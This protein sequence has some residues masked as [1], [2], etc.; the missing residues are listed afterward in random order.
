MIG[1]KKMPFKFKLYMAFYPIRIFF[2]SLTDKLGDEKMRNFNLKGK[3]AIVF[4]VANDQSIAWYIAKALNDSGVRIALAYQERVE[5]LVKPLLRM[6]DNPIAEKC[7]V[8]DDALLDSFFK[9]VEQE[10][11]N[12][13][14]L[15][16]SIAFAK[17]EHLQGKFYDANRRGYQVA[18]EVSSYS[19]AELTRRSLPMMK[20]DGS[21]IA[22]TFDGSS[23]VYPNYNIMGAAK[24]ALESS[25]R[26]LANDVGE[27]GI[28]V[29]AI[30]AGPIKTLAASGISDFDSM[31]KRSREKAPLKRNIDADDVANL[32]LFLC[33][34]MSKNITGQVIYV[35]AGYSIMGI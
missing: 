8:V 7:D 6:L 32:A 3:K 5:Q 2:K 19:L 4:G 15:V 35:D 10:F 24:A 11:G 23:R 20:H 9:K 22:M 27:K 16:H 14:F 18:Q 21:I 13:D 34:D 17:K 28:R 26:Y 29:N 25:V 30:S 33:S 12:V 1:D 31:L